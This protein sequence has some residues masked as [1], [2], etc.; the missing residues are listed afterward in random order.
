MPLDSFH[1]IRV[2]FFHAVKTLLQ[3]WTIILNLIDWSM[4]DQISFSSSS[5]STSSHILLLTL[6]FRINNLFVK[7]DIIVGFVFAPKIRHLSK[8]HDFCLFSSFLWA[9]NNSNAR[10]SP[11]SV[12]T[13][14]WCKE[15]EKARKET[16]AL[17]I[18]TKWV[19]R[20]L[21]DE[22]HVFLFSVCVFM[23]WMKIIRQQTDYRQ[24][25]NFCRGRNSNYIANDN[26]CIWV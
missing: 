1:I 22:S 24:C 17:Y 5:S 9:N 18:W 19:Y 12:G 7:F 3:T 4:R 8:N 14:G 21:N 15:M 23:C 25:V 26:E 10:H 20:W 2:I 6:S 16:H 13:I 11:L